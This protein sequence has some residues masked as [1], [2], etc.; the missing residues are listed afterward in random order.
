MI[1][2][3]LS[4]A[5]ASILFFVVIIFGAVQFFSIRERVLQWF[6]LYWGGGARYLFWFVIL[7]WGWNIW[8]IFRTVIYW[9]CYWYNAVINASKIEPRFSPRDSKLNLLFNPMGKNILHKRFSPVVL[10]I[11][12]IKLYRKKYL[13][14]RE[15]ILL[16]QK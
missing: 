2:L 12:V 16:V 13:V 11:L 3:F 6:N 1:F 14:E 9:H 15:K 10:S 4:H 5:I 7:F 8:D